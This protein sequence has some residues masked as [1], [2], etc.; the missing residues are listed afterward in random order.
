MDYRPLTPDEIVEKVNPDIRARGWAE[1]NVNP[2]TP[3]C[4]VIG[5]FDGPKLA[6]YFVMQLH[7]FLGP[8]VVGPEYRGTEVAF[9]LVHDMDKFMAASN[10]RGV[11]TIADSPVTEHLARRHGMTEIDVPVF[12]KLGEKSQ[13]A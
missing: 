1:L 2:E 9:Q 10:F 4:Y 6:G 7:P 12:I 11:I 8:F 5:A 13:V 3:T